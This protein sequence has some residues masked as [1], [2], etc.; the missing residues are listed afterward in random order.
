M[1][2]ALAFISAIFIIA[3]VFFMW[4]SPINSS[5]IIQP[6]GP[7][8]PIV[9]NCTGAQ[10]IQ[11]ETGA[12]GIQGE[13]GAQGIQGETGAQGI[14]GETGA[15]GIQG[16]TGAQGIQ[17]ETGAQ[18]IQGETGAQGIQGETGAQGIQGETGAQGPAG[19]PLTNNII[20]YLPFDENTG[21]KAWD[22]SGWG[23]D[24]TITGA[25][26]ITGKYIKALNFDGINDYVEVAH[27]SSVTFTTESFTLSAWI[28][29]TNWTIAGEVMAKGA[30]ATDGWRFCVDTT[31]IHFTTFQS[32]AYQDTYAYLSP[33]SNWIYIV[34]V[35]NGANAYIYLNGV[36]ITS[37]QG[38]H[39]NPTTNTRS[40]K[41]GIQD[42]LIS[43][44]FN[45]LIDEI[46]IY[47]RALTIDEI[48]S[49]YSLGPLMHIVGVP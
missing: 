6:P 19:N 47:N 36:D 24:G 10:G 30:W 32:G 2:K 7:V 39:I 35:R 1:N 5:M 14:Q 34:A 29:V 9:T 48:T 45:G 42:N 18:G 13:T 12:Q 3:S 43:Y 22:W 28:K 15:Q 33:T 41:I 26:W 11:G 46:R 31:Y 27:S 20:L 49:I 44:P 4:T 38:T 40:L 37:V 17:G 25:T 16:E 21:T 8:A 23:N